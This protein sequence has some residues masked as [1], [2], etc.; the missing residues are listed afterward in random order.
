MLSDAKTLNVEV[1]NAVFCCM[2]EVPATYKQIYEKIYNVSIKGKSD[3][4]STDL[5]GKFYQE[6]G[7]EKPW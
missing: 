5:Q 7:K 2:K 6:F 3:L 4:C 1:R